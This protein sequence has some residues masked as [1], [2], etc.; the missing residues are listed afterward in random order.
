MAL[1]SELNLKNNLK[2]IYRRG[3]EE[4]GDREEQKYIFRKM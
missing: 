1:R 3:K 2:L 4:T